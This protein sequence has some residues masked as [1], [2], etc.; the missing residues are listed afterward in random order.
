MTNVGF[1]RC[2]AYTFNTFCGLVIKMVS[3]ADMIYPS[4][5]IIR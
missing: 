4:A 1:Y 5:T 2:E 3:S